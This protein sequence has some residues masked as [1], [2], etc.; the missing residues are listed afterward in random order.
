MRYF[1]EGL[2]GDLQA[3]VSLGQPTTFQEAE[4]LARMKDIVNKRQGV[5]DTQQIITQM[6]TMFSELKGQSAESTKV[7][8]AV[9]PSPG[10]SA[11]DKRFDELSKQMRQIQKQLQQNQHSNANYA[12]AAYD[13]QIPPSRSFS[14]RNWQEQPNR[15][16]DQLQRQVA[17]L[18]NDMRRYQNPRRP[19]FRSFGR[20]FR[21]TEGDPIC[22][23]CNR[24]GHT[25][26][27]CRQRNRDPR[28]PPPQNRAPPSGPS[29]QRLNHSQLNG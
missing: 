17:R 13:R 27:V 29:S 18:E 3:H 4:S 9:A 28:V 1:I 21:S 14:P 25:W 2:Q 5:S 7:M 19:D 6:K 15:Q 11:N 16:Y 8:A 24:V 12:M 23:F 26:R 22:T 10:P 20:S